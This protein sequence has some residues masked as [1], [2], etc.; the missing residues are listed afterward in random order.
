MTVTTSTALIALVHDIPGSQHRPT[1]AS[2]RRRRLRAA[3][4]AGTCASKHALLAEGCRHDRTD[5][6]CRC[7]IVG[8][9][10]PPPALTRVRPGDRRRV[11]APRGGPRMPD[12]AHAV[13]G[14]APRRRDVGPAADPP[15]PGGNA[16]LGQP[17]RHAAG[18][19]GGRAVLVS[20]T[21]RPARGE[22][23]AARLPP[24]PPRRA[25]APRPRHSPCPAFAHWREDALPS[26]RQRATQ[27][28]GTCLWACPAGERGEDEGAS[29]ETGRAELCPYIRHAATTVEDPAEDQVDSKLRP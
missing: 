23:S 10:V 17:H 21:R 2:P 20:P 19:W 29:V 22:G 27:A 4:Q 24:L 11:E 13:G 26:P 6:R 25:R 18:G 1:P 12:R 28:I 14:A 9:L 16:G 5:V 8:P 15:R 7:S 3:D